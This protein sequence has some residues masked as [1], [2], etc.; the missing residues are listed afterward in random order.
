MN[1]S[2]GGSVTLD[3]PSTGTDYTQTLVGVS[4]T[5]APIVLG[6][7]QNTTSGTSV[8]YL[9]IPSWVKRITVMFNSVST[10]G[11]N[12]VIVQLGSTSYKTTGYLG[13][14]GWVGASS[15][16]F[17]ITDGF[18]FC[19]VDATQIHSGTMTISYMGNNMWAFA[20]CAGRSSGPY[21]IVGGGSVTLSGVLDRLRVTT[22]GQTDAFD[23]GSV[24]IMYE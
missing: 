2:G 1:S 21:V 4:T 13:G 3:V 12:S 18:C 5:L 8:E 6:T 14:V 20:S 16:G 19:V 23:L 17:A 11:T 22:S 15:T 10:N 7:A 24:N 9:N